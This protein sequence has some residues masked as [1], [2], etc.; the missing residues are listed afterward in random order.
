MKNRIRLLATWVG[1]LLLSS[2]L[3]LSTSSVA[4][5]LPP[6]VVYIMADELGYYEPSFMGN[7]N[8]KTPNVDKIA[9]EGIVFKNM[10]AGS[11]VCAPT[12]CC[13]MTGKHSGHTSV[14]SNGG[15]T[16]ARTRFLLTFRTRHRTAISVFLTKM[17]LG[18]STKTNRGPNPL[19][20]MQRWSA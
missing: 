7:P 5:D 4:A 17:L 11:C 13:L 16:P 1:A 2:A 14:R 12:R 6:N 9:S 8:I 19:D 15:G 20:A 3:H 18:Q 10:F